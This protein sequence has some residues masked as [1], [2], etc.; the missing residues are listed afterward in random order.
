MVRLEALDD[1]VMAVSTELLGRGPNEVGST[2]RSALG[3]LAG[4]VGADRAYVLKLSVEGRS[5]GD[6][7]EEWWADGVEPLATA[8]TDLH[9]DA[10]RFWFRSLRSGDVVRIDDVE[11]LDGHAPEAAAALRG[12]GVRSILFV[13]L[14]AQATPVGFIGFEGRRRSISWSDDTVSRMRIVGELIVAAVERCEGDLERARIATALAARNDELE[15]SNHELQQFASVVSH[16]LLQPLAVLQGFVDQLVRIGVEHPENAELAKACGEAATRASR[17]MR[18]L[19]DDVLAVARAGAPMSGAEP[20]DLNEVL[21]EVVTDLDEAIDSTGAVVVL[22]DLPS[23]EGSP[24]RLR[25]LFQNLVANAV[26]FHVPERP[27]TVRVSGVVDRE[28]CVVTVADDG[29]GVAP[30]EREAVFEMF[31]RSADAADAAGSG[32]GLSICARVV[33]AHGGT[34]AIGESDEGGCRVEVAL[35]RRQPA[36]S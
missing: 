5:I 31:A 8:I 28:R 27:P 24:T 2:I 14:L 11:E 4:V 23:I 34:I 33:A 18:M 6:A 20:V 3:R 26:K 12:D 35:P 1:L 7:F 9:V 15:R 13:P 32:I 21:A 17:R 30:A 19:V 22:D 25:Q 16:D 36:R 10:Q 29:I